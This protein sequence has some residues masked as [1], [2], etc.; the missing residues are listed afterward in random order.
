MNKLITTIGSMLFVCMIFTSCGSD[1]KSEE[2]KAPELTEKQKDNK[3]LAEKFCKY[4]NIALQIRDMDTQYELTGEYEDE[5]KY[6]LLQEEAENIEN[7][8][9]NHVEMLEKKYENEEDNLKIAQADFNF[10][11]KECEK[12]KSDIEKLMG[13]D[14]FFN[15]MEQEMLSDYDANG[16]PIEENLD[17]GW[18]EVDQNN[19]L[20][21]C[22][23]EYEMD[24]RAYCDCALEIVMSMYESYDETNELMTED[25]VMEIAEACSYA[26]DVTEGWSEDVTEGWSEVEQNAF[27]QA[28]IA[29]ND[30]DFM[31][32]YCDCALD[33]VM[34]MYDSPEEAELM[35]EDDIMEI[36]EACSY[37]FD[38]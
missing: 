4:F 9:S 34:S 3:M 17:Y 2:N 15:S 20:D 5:D 23:S 10:F 28:C 14:T 12:C 1:K 32:A 31:P 35:T 37:T 30:A 38:M 25:D 8:M 7:E 19:F 36:A 11:K 13:W 29:E 16:N 26:L 27:V 18:S 6:L 22:N 33:I 24:M 21:D